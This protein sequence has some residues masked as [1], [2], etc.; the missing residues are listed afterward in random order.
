M[1]FV[2]RTAEKFLTRPDIAGSN[3]PFELTEIIDACMAAVGSTCRDK[4]IKVFN[5]SLQLFNM[6]IHSSKVEKDYAATTKMLRCIKK[7]CILEKFLLKSEESNTRLTNKIHEALLDLSYLEQVG[8]NPLAQAVI[9]NII[10]H[11]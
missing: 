5:P 8:E 3:L 9:D 7:E 10:K 1:K 2:L 4:V 6:V 11:N